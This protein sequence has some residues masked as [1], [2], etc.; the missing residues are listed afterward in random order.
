M[1]E[2]VKKQDLRPH[3]IVVRKTGPAT[4]Q[5]LL[6][7]GTLYLPAR[8]DA[9]LCERALTALGEQPEGDYYCPLDIAMA[10]HFEHEHAMSL[11]ELH[12]RLHHLRELELHGPVERAQRMWLRLR[13]EL[14]AYGLGLVWERESTVWSVFVLNDLQECH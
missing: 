10:A 11:V 13:N 1:L 12:E 6:F 5:I 14:L 7:D 2:R 8:P 9:S 3:T 4:A